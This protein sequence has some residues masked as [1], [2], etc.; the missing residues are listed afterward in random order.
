[1]A[2]AVK[3]QFW[4]KN[5][6]PMEAF[7]L[8]SCFTQTHRKGLVKAVSRWKCS[9]ISVNSSVVQSIISLS[10]DLLVDKMED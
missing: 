3:M 5:K 1:M 2:G 7:L 6:I 10:K 4:F 9:W 8:G